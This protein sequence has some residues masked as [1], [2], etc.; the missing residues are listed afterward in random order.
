MAV[1]C[2]LSWSFQYKELSLVLEEDGSPLLFDSETEAEEYAKGNL[3]FEWK[4]IELE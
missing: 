3:N 1:F 2:I 4:V